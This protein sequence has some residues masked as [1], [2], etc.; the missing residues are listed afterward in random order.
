MNDHKLLE[1]STRLAI[2]EAYDRGDKIRE[3]EERFGVPRSTI[4]WVL[5]KEGRTANRIQR[6]RRLVGDDQQLAQLYAVVSAQED[7]I[8]ELEQAC[9]D[10][11]N[12]GLEL[13]RHEAEIRKLIE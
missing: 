12:L 11:L 5:E 2:A 6:G 7:R 9:R 3:I 1:D 13:G 10:L 8:R 4:Y